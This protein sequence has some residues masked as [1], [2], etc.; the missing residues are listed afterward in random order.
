[1][2]HCQLQVLVGRLERLR[3]RGSRRQRTCAAPRSSDEGKAARSAAQVRA[4]VRHADRLPPRVLLGLA[5]RTTPYCQNELRKQRQTCTCT[6]RFAGAEERS[7]HCFCLTGRGAGT[8]E[9]CVHSR[10]Y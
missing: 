3:Q 4:C 6:Q 2:L 8:S 10:S 9:V 1:M 7:L 5:Q